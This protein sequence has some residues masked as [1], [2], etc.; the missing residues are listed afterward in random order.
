MVGYDTYDPIRNSRLFNIVSK[1]IVVFTRDG[2]CQD[3]SS[4]WLSH[5][6]KNHS[7]RRETVQELASAFLGLYT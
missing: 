3:S 2:A 4:D 5:R 6:S 7:R 1:L